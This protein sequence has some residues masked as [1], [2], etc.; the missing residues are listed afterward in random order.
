MTAVK[1]YKNLQIFIKDQE[2]HPSQWK[3]PERGN[4]LRKL[5]S[6]LKNTAHNQFN[7]DRNYFV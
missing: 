1:R 6:Y 2:S 5:G 7:W 3:I 4:K